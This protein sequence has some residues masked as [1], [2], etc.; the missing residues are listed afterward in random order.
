MDISLTTSTH[1]YQKYGLGT[2]LLFSFCWIVSLPILAA[3]YFS[4]DAINSLIPGSFELFHQN[5]FSGIWGYMRDWLANGRFFPLSVISSVTV[6]YLFSDILSYQILRTFFIWLSLFAFA[7]LIKQ[8]TKNTNAS[9]LFILCVPICWSVRNFPDPLTSFAIFLPLLTLFIALSLIFY[10]KF[11]ET[12]KSA[13]LALSLFLYVLALSTYEVGVTEL[14]LLPILIW[15]GPYANKRLHSSFVPYCLLTVVYAVINFRLRYNSTGMYDGIELGRLANFFPTF[16]A[17][18]A[19]SL[20]L[21]YRLFS[22]Q[23]EIPLQELL[24]Q[25]FNQ[26]YSLLLIGYFFAISL[27]GLYYCLRKIYFSQ[28]TIIC[29][30]LLGLVLMMIPAALIGSSVKYQHMV[31]L[32]KGY[33]SVYLQY[34]GLSLFF[35]A[36]VGQFHLIKLNNTVKSLLLFCTALLGSFTLSYALILNS[37][38]VVR[39][40]DVS[41]YKRSLIEEALHHHLFAD[42][43]QHTAII[44]KLYLWNNAEFFMLNAHVKIDHVIDLNDHAAIAFLKNDNQYLL[45]AYHLPGL[46]AGYV[47]LGLIHSVQ[48][49]IIKNH[50]EMVSVIQVNHPRIFITA[51]SSAEFDKILR[52]LT[53]RLALSSRDVS[54]ISDF[55]H[56]MENHNAFI[57]PL[58]GTDY[59][60]PFI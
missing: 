56:H 43:P 29:L 53:V 46:K 9:W 31:S 55:N 12:L 59:V 6:F 33:L 19:S 35:I 3:G 1:K 32:G 28:R 17:Q 14:F 51:T 23:P 30:A 18:L 8:L 42:L 2:L 20:P 7:W 57:V 40:N 49:R 26:P 47:I 10:L 24:Q 58:S 50:F 22:H 25:Y 41:G 11:Q 5:F 21:S 54:N 34:I 44:E 48:T 27:F 15:F 16:L 39:M 60:M 52:M 13:W 36:S 38:V 37:Y 4:D 45:D